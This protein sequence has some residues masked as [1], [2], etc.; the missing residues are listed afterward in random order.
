[1]HGVGRNSPTGFAAI[2]WQGVNLL[3]SF[4]WRRSISLG[5]PSLQSSFVLHQGSN[6]QQEKACNN[7][8]CCWCSQFCKEQS[9][10]TTSSCPDCWEG[11]DTPMLMANSLVAKPPYWVYSQ[12]LKCLR[13]SKDRSVI[14]R[15]G[16]KS[17]A[18]AKWK[19]VRVNLQG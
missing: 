10:S 13:H 7:H 14:E 4:C 15:H 17:A 19:S 2:L 11:G 5:D 9:A 12:V 16:C 6:L 3:E 1:M 18:M 8:V